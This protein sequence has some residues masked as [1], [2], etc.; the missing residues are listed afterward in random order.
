MYRDW[1][2]ESQPQPPEPRFLDRDGYTLYGHD[3]GTPPFGGARVEA[4]RL[5]ELFY[6]ERMPT[7]R[8]QKATA[9]ETKE[10]LHK[11]FYWSQLKWYG[12]K[13][14]R[15]ESLFWL[16]KKLSDA[17]QLGKVRILRFSSSKRGQ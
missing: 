1:T 6:P 10:L 15:N 13:F 5:L 16:R 9:L 14:Q 3:F 8:E 17:V 2:P 4:S 7:K 12:I 11:S